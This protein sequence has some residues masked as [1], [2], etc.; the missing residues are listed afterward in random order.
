[1]ISSKKENFSIRR[2]ISFVK[3]LP[4]V[5]QCLQKFKL[6]ENPDCD[7]I[8]ELIE[9]EFASYLHYE[10]FQSILEKYCTDSEKDHPHLKYSLYLKNYIETLDVENFVYINPGLKRFSESEKIYLKI[11]TDRQMAE[12]KMAEIKQLEDSIATILGN[13]RPSDLILIDVKDGCLILTFL[14]PA[15]TAHA[16]FANEL[17]VDQIERLHSLSVLWLKYEDFEI[18][19]RVVPNLKALLLHIIDVGHG[20]AVLLQHGKLWK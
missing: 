10:I 16:I 19:C 18:D 13:M 17:R 20:F 9:S 14:L 8:F 15:S 5:K 7:D 3:G 2:L 6:P 11:D 4:S 12:I 1:M